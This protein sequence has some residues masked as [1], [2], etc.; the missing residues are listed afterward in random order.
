MIVVDASVVVAAL[1]GHAGASARL[2]TETCHAPHLVDA[3]V[4]HVLRRLVARREVDGP[5]APGLLRAS[6]SFVDR[7]HDMTGRLATT[8]WGLH[9]N[10]SFYDALYVGLA[11]LLGCPFVTADRRLTR[12]PHL[13]IA[14]EV[15]Q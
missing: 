13:G 15:V 3:E 5:A 14:V 8:A 12:A 1:R 11:R 4:G 6:A 2:R 9:D 7:R 10:V